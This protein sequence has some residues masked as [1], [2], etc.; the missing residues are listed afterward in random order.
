MNKINYFDFENCNAVI[1]GGGSGLGYE[2][3]KGLLSYGCNVI[4][5]GR[6][7]S[8]LEKSV[9]KLNKISESFC[10]SVACDISDE[11]SLNNAFQKIRNIFK[12]KLNIA[13]NSAGFNIRNKI[14]DVTLKEWQS[15]INVN[16]SGAFLF[17]REFYPILNNANFGR[18][19][20]IASIFSS[21]SFSDRSSYSS[22]KGGVLQLTKTLAIE[23]A[24]TKIT[25][26][27]ISP[28]PFLTDI[29]KPV[30]DN[31]EN[32][33]KFC[34]NIPKE[35]FGKPHEIITSCLFLSSRYSS[36]INGSDIVVDGGWLCS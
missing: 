8:K 13:I 15:I 25:V 2:M 4:I 12:N 26:N 5:I 24:K 33:K 32:Y 35:R 29:N 1:A 36:Y 27:S 30:L 9:K 31:P 11:N 21:I 3:A 34:L 16:L 18:L 7:K 23:W 20:N 17:A 6:N 22:S 10:D 28:G 19:I 14:T